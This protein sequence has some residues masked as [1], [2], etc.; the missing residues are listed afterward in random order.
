VRGKGKITR[1]KPIEKQEIIQ[2]PLSRVGRHR[3]PN[4]KTQG[5]PPSGKQHRSVVK[6]PPTPPLGCLA[7][8]SPALHNTHIT[9]PTPSP[10]FQL[11][12]SDPHRL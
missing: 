7:K 11:S 5:A 9:L 1:D 12:Y 2:D 8:D 3:A 10:S 6:I 4:K